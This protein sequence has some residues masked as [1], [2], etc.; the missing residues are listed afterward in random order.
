M[1]VSYQKEKL[2]ATCQGV[3]KVLKNKGF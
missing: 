3:Q 1:R 2:I